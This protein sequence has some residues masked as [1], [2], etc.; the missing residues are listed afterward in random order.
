MRLGKPL[1]FDFSG[2]PPEPDWVVEGLFERGTLTV[3]AAA[4]SAGK[5][6]LCASLAV[7]VIRHQPWLERATNGNRVLYIDGENHPRITHWR[8]QGLGM[9]NE[10]RPLLRYYLRQGIRIGEGQWL[11][12]VEAEIEQFKPDLVVLDTATSTLAVKSANDNSEVGAI[13]TQ[14][15]GLC[16]HDLALVLL[17]HERKPPAGDTGK[18]DAGAAILGGIQWQGQADSHLSVSKVGKVQ[19]RRAPDGGIT[20]RY[21][22]R[23]DVPKNREGEDGS[24]EWAIVSHHDPDGKP[25]P[26]ATS[27]VSGDA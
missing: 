25:I 27:I 21:C 15:R 22:L 10:D 23:L 12:K 24:E 17:H 19:K 6:F 3:V 9:T 20:K 18:R 14:L 11:A 8:L 4:P 13:M 5:S 2:S 16:G 26:G 1:Y 7:A